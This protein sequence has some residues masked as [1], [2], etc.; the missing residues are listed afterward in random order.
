[1]RINI[2][3]QIPLI[4]HQIQRA[5]QHIH[6]ARRRLR[7]VPTRDVVLGRG[8]AVAQQ[9]GGQLGHR[10]CLVRYAVRGAFAR[11]GDVVCE[12]CEPDFRRA[13]RVQVDGY[14]LASQH[15]GGEDGEGAA[16]RVSRG[17]DFVAW[18]FCLGFFDD[19][20]HIG[21][22]FEPRLPESDARDAGAA[23]TG[24]RDGEVEVGEP[25]ADGARAAEGEYN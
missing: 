25:V 1:M 2:E 18:V 7:I 4:A 17:Y 16:E 3:S 8:V 11:V 10:I 20:K 24:G 13:V 12:A 9:R 5:R 19:G 23:D 14:A 21:L 22:R 15:A 6:I